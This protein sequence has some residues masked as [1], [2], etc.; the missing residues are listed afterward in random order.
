MYLFFDVE[1]TGLPKNWKA[2]VTDLDNWP[3]LVQL[4][5]LYYD[6]NG[7]KISGGDFIIKPDGFSIPKEASGI[8]GISTE[9]AIR[10]G[11]PLSLVLQ[12]F[13]SLIDL[14]EVL[15]AHNMSFD[16]N[17]V[18]AEFLRLGMRNPIPAKRKICTMESST[19]F[20]AIPGKNGYK[21]PRL[22]ELHYKLFQTGFEEAHNAAVDIT[23][24]A[25]C[26]W[27]LKRIGIL[28]PNNK[29]SMISSNTKNNSIC[30][31][32]MNNNG[33]RPQLSEGLQDFIND[34][35]EGIIIKG[36][37]FDKN[38][39]WLRKFCADEGVDY[40]VIKK[41]IENF[42]QFFLDFNTIHFS[43]LDRRVL[44][45]QSW[46]SYV[47]D[48]LFEKL[49]SVEHLPGR[50]FVAWS[51]IPS[52]TF[53]MGGGEKTNHTVT[54]NAFRMSRFAVTFKQYD[55]YCEATGI[56]KPDDNGWKRDNNP[57]INV[58]WFDANAFAK[59]MGCRLPTEAEWEYAC[60]AGTTTPF[61]TGNNL[62][63]SQANFK[64]DFEGFPHYKTNAIRPKGLCRG[65]PIPVGSF[66]PNDFGLYDMHGNVQEWCN[67]WYDKYLLEEQIN[68]KGPEN[69]PIIQFYDGSLEGPQRVLRGGSWFSGFWSCSS[70]ARSWNKPDEYS[71]FIGFRLAFDY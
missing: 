70:H 52:G 19:N 7:N 61:Y 30:M 16:E 32:G 39:T 66:A 25:K 54:L 62:T 28:M 35:I 5:F 50:P 57:V 45:M 46:L 2:P 6:R 1:T 67:D 9:R 43:T 53:I 8:H 22:S 24:T 37:S 23:V 31:E 60:R 14:A 63:T 71:D 3:R 59:W 48:N 18:G 51:D 34:M 64:D 29:V 20:C 27:E 69:G 68:P 65:Y 10:E 56:K 11:K 38:N 12:Q 36:G 41:N 47:N 33:N 55:M 21:W 15:V 13:K 42:I 58:N 49:L 17:I 44:K 26:F 4:A 40:S